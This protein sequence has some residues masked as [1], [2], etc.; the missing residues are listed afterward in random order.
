MS[1]VK[2]GILEYVG[3]DCMEPQDCFSISVVIMLD[4]DIIILLLVINT[5]D[6]SFIFSLLSITR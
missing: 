4:L 3:I 1:L 6:N 2:C 5:C